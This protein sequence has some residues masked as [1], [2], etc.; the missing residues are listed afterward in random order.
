ML[1]FSHYYRPP[2]AIFKIHPANPRSLLWWKEV[3]IYYHLSKTIQFKTKS[4]TFKKLNYIF[5]VAKRP[6]YFLCYIIIFLNVIALPKIQMLYVLCPNHIL[7]LLW[8]WIASGLAPTKRFLKLASIREENS[9]ILY[10]LISWRISLEMWY[11]NKCIK[12]LHSIAVGFS[13]VYRKI[14]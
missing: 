13:R 9:W 12:Y 8:N 2:D 3:S 6:Y 4:I 1:Q 5:Y 14:G 11:C 7:L 10:H